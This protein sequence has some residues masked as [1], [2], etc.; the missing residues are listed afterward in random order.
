MSPEDSRT[1]GTLLPCQLQ[2]ARKEAVCGRGRDGGNGNNAGLENLDAFHCG[3]LTDAMRSL[4][5]TAVAAA[6]PPLTPSRGQIGHSG[7]RQGR[8]AQ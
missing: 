5:N 4:V 3:F 7:H 8:L 2:V 6:S 1:L